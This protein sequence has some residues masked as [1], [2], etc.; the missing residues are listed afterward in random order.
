MARTGMANLILTWRRMVDDAGTAVWSADQAQEILDRRRMD[1]WAEEL[2]AI[3]VEIDS[4][5]KW[6]T[7][8]SQ[9]ENFEEISSGTT[10]WRLY[11]ANGSAASTANY[12]PDYTRGLV[13][14]AADQEGTTYYLD[15][16]SYDLH[17]AAADA[18][19]ERA[20]KVSSYYSFGSEGKTFSRSDWFKHCH[21]MAKLYAGMSKPVYVTIRRED[22]NP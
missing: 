12:T 19:R 7:Y 6:Y 18:W 8:A 17:S 15:G 10:I 20:G 21:E 2:T 5:T 4:D 22:V 9:Y 1:V 3:P 14:F 16:R 13:T 11:D